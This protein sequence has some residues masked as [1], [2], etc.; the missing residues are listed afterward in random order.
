M[1]TSQIYDL[2]IRIRIQYRMLNIRTQ[3]RIDL[4]PFKRIRC[5][6]RSENIR[7]V[8]ISS[9]QRSKS[10]FLAYKG[11]ATICSSAAPAPAKKQ[12]RRSSAKAKHVL[13]Y[14]STQH[15]CTQSQPFNALHR[16]IHVHPTHSYGICIIS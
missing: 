3:I 13:R 15:T 2:S 12:H 10:P 8:F 14:P 11:G 6:I 1:S 7:T 5:R 4:N 16:W 9:G